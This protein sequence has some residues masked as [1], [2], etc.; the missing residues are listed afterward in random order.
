[1]V[2]GSPGGRSI[3][4]TVLETIVNVVDFG[5][6]AQEAVDAGRFCHE[7]FPDEITYERS[8]FSADALR[9]LRAKKHRLREI[10][11]QGVAEVI[12]FD[13]VRNAWEGGCDRRE[14]DGGVGLP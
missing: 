7:W 6:N 5:M 9:A 14:A 2:T 8:A 4:G 13:A 12:V 3:I 1:M 11:S 10:K